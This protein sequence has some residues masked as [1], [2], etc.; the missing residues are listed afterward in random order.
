MWLDWDLLTNASCT[1][2]Q[3]HVDVASLSLDQPSWASPANGK[4]LSL[5]FVSVPDM[6]TDFCEST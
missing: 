4:K 6:V 5:G 1:A 3:R 2:P